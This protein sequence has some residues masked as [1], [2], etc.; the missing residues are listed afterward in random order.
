MGIYSISSKDSSSANYA[1]ATGNQLECE[2]ELSESELNQSSKSNQTKLKK[3][4]IRLDVVKKT[5][6]RYK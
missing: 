3:Y 6:F 1:K 4:S 5:I 2:S